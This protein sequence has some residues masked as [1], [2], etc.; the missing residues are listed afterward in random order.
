MRAGRCSERR[1]VYEYGYIVAYEGL[2]EKRARQLHENEEELRE[3]LKGFDEDWKKGFIQGLQ[4]RFAFER[5]K[6]G[7]YP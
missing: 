7:F 4:D 5:G 2:T 1:E 6:K 3:Y